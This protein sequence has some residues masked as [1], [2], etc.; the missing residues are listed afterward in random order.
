MAENKESGV[1]LIVATLAACDLRPLLDSLETQTCPDYECI[2]VDQS[3]AQ[4]AETVVKGYRNI[5]YVHS[6]RKGNSFNRN[7]GIAHARYPFLGFPD[8]D[9]YYAP[10]VIE[11]VLRAFSASSA[12]TAGVSGVWMDSI[13]GEL[14]MGSKTAKRANWIDVWSSVT[15]LTLFLRAGVVRD[16][17]GYDESFGLGS[18]FFRGGEET[19]LTLKVLET[20]NNIIYHPEIVVWHRQDKYVLNKPEKQWGYEE[21]WG[22]LFRKWSSRGPRQGL[23]RCAFLFFLCRSFL[24]ACLWMLRGNHQYANLYWN[25]NRA[26][27]AGWSKYGRQVNRK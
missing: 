21:A 9:C 27:F 16:V 3:P 6:L 7:I 8:D 25:K 17:K 26:R 15:N 24:A 19:D 23:I 22:A 11:K 20:G 4:K 14:A 1:S 5:K 2:I 13:T 10:D 18:D 12:E